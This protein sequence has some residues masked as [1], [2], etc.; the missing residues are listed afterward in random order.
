MPRIRILTET[1]LRAAVSLDADAVDCIEDAFR[2]LATGDVV[3][4]PVLSMPIAAHNGEV[5]VKTAYIHGVSGFAVKVSP[6]FFNNPK[7]GLP[8][9]SGLMVLFSAETGQTQALLLDNGYLTDLRT[10]AAGAVAARHLARAEASRAC[11]LGTGMQAR[12]QLAALS[13]VRPLE[14]AVIW[15]RD[16]AKADA[17]AREMTAALGLPVTAEADAEAA[18]KGAGMIVTTTPATQPILMAG[19]LQPGQHVTAMG[20]DQHGKGEL[21]PACIPRADLYVPDRL[22]QTREMGEL[23]N[24]IAAGLVPADTPFAELGEIIA[25]TVPGRPSDDAITLADLTGTGIQD[26][27]IATLAFS[28]ACDAGAG[29]IIDS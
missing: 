18:V 20:S 13:L 29:T 26:T 17:A 28:R 23:Q 9:T 16:A 2:A 8:S 6:G 14:S 12:M 19:W 7:I 21:D 11:I 27:A 15:G 3:M 10:A 24:A 22:G 4:P 5:D 1:D 25:G